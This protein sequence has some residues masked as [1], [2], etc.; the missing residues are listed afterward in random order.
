MKFKAGLIALLVT[1]LLLYAVTGNARPV[2]F[3]DLCAGY[4]ISKRG[5]DVLIRCP[6]DQHQ[7]PWMTIT[8]CPK[9]KV[10]RHRNGDVT[11]AC[12]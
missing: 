10:T 8:K 5:D 9:P 1:V 11:I 12:T 2:K 7:Q 3:A 4:T 6:G